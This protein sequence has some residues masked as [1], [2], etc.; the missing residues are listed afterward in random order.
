M[1]SQQCGGTITFNLIRLEGARARVPLEKGPENIAA[2]CQTRP[3]FRAARPQRERE[4]EKREGL[5]FSHMLLTVLVNHTGQEHICT[6]R[7]RE[8]AQNW[9]EARPR[10]TREGYFGTE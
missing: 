3:N 6:R 7:D 5:S 4:R 8:R 1:E 10:L 9:A 2:E